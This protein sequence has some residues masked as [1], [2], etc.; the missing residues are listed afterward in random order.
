M[1][2]VLPALFVLTLLNLVGCGSKDDAD[3][4][5]ARIQKTPGAQAP[6]ATGETPTKAGPKPTKAG[7]K[8]TKAGPNPTL[9]KAEGHY[10]Q[11]LKYLSDA[12]SQLDP[13]RRVDLLEDAE[14][15]FAAAIAL[16]HPDEILRLYHALAQSYADRPWLESVP[17]FPEAIIKRFGPVL[18]MMYLRAGN[19]S[20]AHLLE[21]GALMHTNPVA[22]E[23]FLAN[24]PLGPQSIV[25]VR[26]GAQIRCDPEE[27]SR[28]GRIGQA[29]DGSWIDVDGN[30]KLNLPQVVEKRGWMNQGAW[31]KRA[32]W[33]GKMFWPVRVSGGPPVPNYHEP[34]VYDDTPPDCVKGCCGSQHARMKF[35]IHAAKS[36]P[37][38]MVQKEHW[39]SV[40]PTGE[41]TKTRY[42]DPF[43]TTECSSVP[44]PWLAVTYRQSLQALCTISKGDWTAGCG[45]VARDQ[46]RIKL[47]RRFAYEDAIQEPLLEG[48]LAKGMTR[49]MLQCAIGDSLRVTSVRPGR[50][51]LVEVLEAPDL[52]ARFTFRDGLLQSWEIDEEALEILEEEL[53]GDMGGDFEEE[54]MWEEGLDPEEEELDE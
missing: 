36:W 33:E 15:H 44:V 46:A 49:I 52:A 14:E 34:Y 47:G 27:A 9:V 45:D 30:A 3:G 40:E 25:L 10:V 32:M 42:R 4:D 22:W 51:H 20:G 2:F 6:A 31:Q 1:R 7:P 26:Q 43:G 28:S 50:E 23:S 17:D 38:R 16:Q 5:P 8:P 35:W 53:E 12:M 41:E 37:N 54:E 18:A 21:G 13:A 39:R 48:K 24:H 29:F 11:A 19:S